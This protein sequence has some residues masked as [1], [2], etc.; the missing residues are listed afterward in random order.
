MQTKRKA[1]GPAGVHCSLSRSTQQM[2]TNFVSG[3]ILLQKIMRT[4]I[5][6]GIENY[7][8][9]TTAWHMDILEAD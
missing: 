1:T 9:D 2:Y 3:L 5:W 8:G 7:L 6:Q 4:V